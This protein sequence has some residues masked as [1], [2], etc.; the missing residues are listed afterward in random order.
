MMPLDRRG[1]AVSL[2]LGLIA[3]L[4]L[5]WVLWRESRPPPPREPPTAEALRA[6]LAHAGV[7][8]VQPLSTT[9]P[10]GPVGVALPQ[11]PPPTAAARPVS[12]DLSRIAFD[13]QAGRYRLAGANGARL[14]LT[15]HPAVQRA[16]DGILDGKEVD[17][18]AVVAIEP[19]TGRVLA[20]AERSSSA[21]WKHPALQAMPPAASVFKIVTAAALVEKAGLPADQP[22][23]FHGGLHGFNERH[24][25]D[26]ARADTRC[27]S[28]A[29]ALGR[30]S[31]VVFGKLARKH[32]DPAR[33][34]EVA[35]AFGF[36]KEIPFPL[37]IESSR[38]SIPEEPLEYARAAAGFHHTTLSPMHGALI[39]AAIG[40]GGAMMAPVLVDEALVGG[41]PLPAAMPMVI[42][43]VVTDATARTL[44]QMMVTTTELGTASRYFRKRGPALQGI[45]VAGK[46]GSL[47]DK[48]EDGTRRHYSWWVGFAPAENPRIAV[49]ALVVNVTGW[50]VKSTYIAREVL[51]AFFAHESG[52]EVSAR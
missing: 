21:D 40:N 3:G 47:S 31:N 8:T 44:T 2:S 13:A 37:V 18:G 50:R 29:E 4:A 43:R 22:T 24:L 7:N 51:E 16:A 6:R 48:D 19:K 28:I 30:S 32:L 9:P 46:T 17:V 11:A 49:A 41:K 14:A 42:Q 25:V 33:L 20:L 26:N 45:A 35:R 27:E 38:V 15:L 39:A 52:H 23:C 5:A 36:D 34:T 10:A 12:Y 1:V